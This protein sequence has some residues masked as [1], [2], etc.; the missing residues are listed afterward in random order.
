[1]RFL[2]KKLYLSTLEVIH[3]HILG[4]AIRE[5]KLEHNSLVNMLYEL[6]HQLKSENKNDVIFLFFITN[7]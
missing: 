1:M 6:I 2:S 4:S 3:D 5:N 7:D